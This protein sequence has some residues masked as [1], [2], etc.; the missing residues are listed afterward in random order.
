MRLLMNDVM[1]F[2]TKTNQWKCFYFLGLVMIF[3][4]LVQAQCPNN[5]ALTPTAWGAG[6]GS[7]VYSNGQ[8][9]IVGKGD[10]S[11]EQNFENGYADLMTLTGNG[12]FIAEVLSISGRRNSNAAAG[13]FI[14]GQTDAG[15]DG[16]LLWI[17]G[18]RSDFYQFD[19]RINDGP[20]TQIESVSCSLP[21]WLRIQNSG[22]V[23]YPA[24]STN[25]NTW[26]LLP[27]LDM[28]NDNEF[29]AGSTLACGLFVWSG[30]VS[31]PTTA[32]FGNV[33]VNNSFT[34]YP[35]FTPDVTS[36]PTATKT[37]TPN[38]TLT[39]TRLTTA[40]PSYTF[41]PTLT[42]MPSHTFSPTPFLSPTPTVSPT[43]T[44]TPPPGAKVWPNPFT[45]QLPTNN[46]TRFPLPSSHGS[47]HLLIADLKRR[48]VRSSD[49]SPGME[50]QWDGKDDGG[51]VVA[52]GVYLY[53]LE[54][55]GTVRRGTVT[56][57][58]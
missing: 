36:T 17:D 48:R 23:L 47:G 8:Y 38:L 43:P 19:A 25:G 44:P 26:T 56:V 5:P 33:C 50:V 2:G 13:I 21:F 27:A 49:F 12:Q 18:S 55:D 51:N 41:T 30:S 53:L 6:A 39:P 40:T 15:P 29:S 42:I 32:V 37:R 35:T 22:N 1:P 20:L 4:W 31:Q 52:S 11:A 28:R 10:F 57:M 46:V 34:P 45:P 54:T 16:G 9:T 7:A 14:R 3:P 58:R 24:V